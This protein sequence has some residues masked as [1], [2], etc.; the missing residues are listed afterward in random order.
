[1]A[2]GLTVKKQKFMTFLLGAANGNQTLAAKMAG[3]K[4]DN[5]QLA[6]QGSVNMRDPRIQQMIRERLGGMVEPSLRAFEE[7]LNATKRRA[8]MS[9]TGEIQYSDPE[10]DHRVR[11]ATGDRVLDRYERTFSGFAAYF[12]ANVVS[13]QGAG[14]EPPKAEADG[15][16]KEGHADSGFDVAQFIAK[17]DADIDREAAEQG[18]DRAEYP[19]RIKAEMDRELADYDGDCSVDHEVEVCS[20]SVLASREAEPPEADRKL[21]HHDG[22]RGADHVEQNCSTTMAPSLESEQA[23]IDHE[24]HD[25]P[26]GDHGK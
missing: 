24:L 14:A 23:E 9:K 15:T 25:H 8:F 5:R 18:V 19:A 26:G 6:V 12:D 16:N 7:G 13:T 20:P 10:P 1:M 3:Y 17:I 4:G 2:R 22:D 11:T 21:A